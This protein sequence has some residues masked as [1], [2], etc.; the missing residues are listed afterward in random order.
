M[1]PNLKHI[2]GFSLAINIL[3]SVVLV[4]TSTVAL[5]TTLEE[6]MLGITSSILILVVSISR[7]TAQVGLPSF[8]QP[9]ICCDPLHADHP[10]VC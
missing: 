9:N 8:W 3:V 2:L 1:H 5:L 10:Q 6:L 4:Q 7:I